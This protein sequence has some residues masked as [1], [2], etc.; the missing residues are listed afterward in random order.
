M[1]DERRSF[2]D[3]FHARVLD[4]IATLVELDPPAD[5]PEGRFLV[6][7]SAA[8][9]EYERWRYPIGAPTPEEAAAFRAE[10][11]RG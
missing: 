6:S 1:T 9:A 7:I 5:S 3:E 11:E 10:Q 4:V 2:G 8:A